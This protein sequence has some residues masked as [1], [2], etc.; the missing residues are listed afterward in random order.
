MVLLLYK[1]G[2]KPKPRSVKGRVQGADIYIGLAVYCGRG[3]NRLLWC[4]GVYAYKD[5]GVYRLCK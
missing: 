5:K 1:S 3:R 4:G 2:C